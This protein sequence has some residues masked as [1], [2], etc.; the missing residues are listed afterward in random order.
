MGDAAIITIEGTKTNLAKVYPDKSAADLY[1]PIGVIPMIGQNDVDG[2]MFTFSDA[3]KAAQY[4]KPD[5]HVVAARDFPDMGDLATSSLNPFQKKDYE[6]TTT[7]LDAI[8]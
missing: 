7:I 1:K 8:E 2:E 4:A 3:T 5:S 6:Y